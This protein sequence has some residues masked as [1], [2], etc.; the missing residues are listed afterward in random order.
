MAAAYVGEVSAEAFVA[1]VGS[2]WPLPVR[3][4]GSRKKWSREILLKAV[5]ARHGMESTTDQE[6]EDI[7]NLI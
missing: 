3:G 6:P 2:I 4:K 1:K 5:R 7:V